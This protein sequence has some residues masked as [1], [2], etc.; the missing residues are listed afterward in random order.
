MTVKVSPEKCSSPWYW[1]CFEK[2]GYNPQKDSLLCISI[3]VF[4][5]DTLVFEHQE[6][7]QKVGSE[8]YKREA[9]YIYQ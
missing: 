7:K 4:K 6:S 1:I 9:F 5:V 2:H 8:K 3:C